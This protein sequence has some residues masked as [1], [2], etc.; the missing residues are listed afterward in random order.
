M[1]PSL[2]YDEK[3]VSQIYSKLVLV[4]ISS[5]CVGET[6][7]LEGHHTSRAI[8]SFVR[9]LTI[10]FRISSKNFSPIN[11]PVNRFPR[12]AFS[13][14]PSFEDMVVRGFCRQRPEEVISFSV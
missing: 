1:R 10:F 9:A 12:R 6:E 5:F 4:K 8:E 7:L 14:R 2:A 13:E 3:Q 11:S